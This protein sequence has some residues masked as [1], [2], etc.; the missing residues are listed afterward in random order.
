MAGYAKPVTVGF[1]I[2][3]AAASI[4]SGVLFFGGVAVTGGGG[5][6]GVS[7]GVAEAILSTFLLVGFIGFVAGF[8]WTLLRDRRAHR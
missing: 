5:I 7:A 2:G 4:V 3:L 8:G 1:V 6:A